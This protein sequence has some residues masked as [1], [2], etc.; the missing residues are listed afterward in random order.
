M[1]LCF[2]PLKSDYCYSVMCNLGNV[3]P[4]ILYWL[5]VPIY[6]V[7]V[8]CPHIF[9]IGNVS[10]YILYWQCVPVY[11]VLAMCLNIFCI[12]RIFPIVNHSVTHIIVLWILCCHTHISDVTVLQSI[13]PISTRGEIAAMLAKVV[14]V[15]VRRIVARGARDLTNY[16][17]LYF[18]SIKK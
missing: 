11:F 17:I 7:L 13:L 1:F 8:M 3:S 2:G 4:Y 5:F 9:C 15:G 14:V 18:S 10:P 6:S 16:S 12:L